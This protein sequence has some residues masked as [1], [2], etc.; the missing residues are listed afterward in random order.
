[1]SMHRLLVTLVA[2]AGLVPAA[3]AHGAPPA[4]TPVGDDVGF[5]QYGAIAERLGVAADTQALRTPGFTA[6]QRRELAAARAAKLRAAHR[7]DAV[8]G[9]DAPQPGDFTIVLPAA[10]T[11]TRADVLALATRLERLLCGVYT[12]ATAYAQDPGTRMLLAR[13]LASDAADLA[14][15]HRLAGLRPS[16]GLIEPIDVDTAGP[17]IDPYL[18][19]PGSP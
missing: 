15:L 2:L 14:Q 12:S 13:L 8:L 10:Q 5:V 7:L 6:A 19:T 3:A 16:A 4:A 1:M 18:K 9:A 11:R 17:A